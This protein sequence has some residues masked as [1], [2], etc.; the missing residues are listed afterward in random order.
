MSPKTIVFFPEGA[1]GPTNNCV[2]IGAVLRDRG[3][4]VVFVIEESF[5]GTLEEKGFEE[6]LM[7]L[8]PAP[9]AGGGARPVLEGLHP[10]DG[11]GIPKVDL[12]PALGVHRTHLA[13]ARRRSAIRRR[14][15][16]RDLRRA[17]ARRNRRG[18]RLLLSRNPGRR[19][20]LG[21]HRIVQP[22]G[23]EGPGPP[24]D[25]LRTAGRRPLGLGR[26]HGRVQARHRRRPVGVQRVLREPWRHPTAGWR[27]HPRVAVAEPLPLST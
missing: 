18:Q 14:P 8:A 2:G 17:R 5:A 21:P 7:R 20:A 16:R 22:A 12:R 23:A 4:R 10:R 26:L 15:P 11:A 6:R 1:F 13:G 27:A 3:H 24:A 9:E 19:S 25:V